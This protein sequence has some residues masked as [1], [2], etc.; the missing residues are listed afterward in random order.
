MKYSTKNDRVSP[1]HKI[2]IIERFKNN[3]GN[4]IG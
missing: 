1:D 3:R 4:F 2:L